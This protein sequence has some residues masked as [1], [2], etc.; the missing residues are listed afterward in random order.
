MRL[1][2][3]I[4]KMHFYLSSFAFPSLIIGINPF[5]HKSK[6]TS[7]ERKTF[8]RIDFI[9]WHFHHSFLMRYFKMRIKTG[10]WKPSLWILRCKNTILIWNLLVSLWMNGNAC[11]VFSTWTHEHNLYNCSE[12]QFVSILPFLLRKTIMSFTN[13]I[14]KVFKA[15]CQN[16][17]SV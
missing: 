6:T 16:K 1:E 3:F 7:S 14:L 4:W 12:S 8:L 5:S 11:S 10:W 17:I 15:A 13:R 2:E 9:F